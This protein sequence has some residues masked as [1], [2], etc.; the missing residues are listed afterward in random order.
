[1]QQELR[2]MLRLLKQGELLFGVERRYIV[3]DVAEAQLGIALIRKF[4][5]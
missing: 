2:T 5:W 4:H 3:M 1:M